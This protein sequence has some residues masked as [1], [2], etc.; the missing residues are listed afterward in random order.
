MGR[1]VAVQSFE[2]QGKGDVWYDTFQW[3]IIN[4]RE[5]FITCIKEK[6]LK[7]DI[8]HIDIN[9]EVLFIH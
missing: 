5:Y 6:A 4:M 7:S 2:F 1:Y 9:N 3:K 8:L